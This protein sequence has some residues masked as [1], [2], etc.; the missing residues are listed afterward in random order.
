MIKCP[1][2][3]N[4]QGARY[5]IKTTRCFLCSKKIDLGKI[6]PMATFDDRNELRNALMAVKIKDVDP[7]ELMEISQKVPQEERKINK[8]KGK[9]HLRRS[10]LGSSIDHIHLKDLIEI[11]SE[12]GYDMDEIHRTIDELV[13][14]GLLYRPDMETVASVK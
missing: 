14:K 5:P 13:E 8:G 12:Y 11:I 10:I 2:C 7:E 6:G 9:D 3:K 1:Y 4:I